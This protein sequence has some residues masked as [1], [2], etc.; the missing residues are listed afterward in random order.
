MAIKRAK[1]EEMVVKLRQVEGLTG[2]GMSRS[3]AIGQTSMT[4]Q[5]YYR[6]SAGG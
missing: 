3:D 5:T 2:Q 6:W 1:P 4:E